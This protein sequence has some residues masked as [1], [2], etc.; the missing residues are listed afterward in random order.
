MMM[1]T[2]FLP[3]EKNFI[4]KRNKKFIGKVIRKQAKEYL[5]KGDMHVVKDTTKE[6][7]IQEIFMALCSSH[8]PHYHLDKTVYSKNIIYS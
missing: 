6:K 4:S 1:I 2:P 3:I 8:F 5:R 7:N